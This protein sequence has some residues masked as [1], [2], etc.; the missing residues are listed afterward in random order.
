MKF[1]VLRKSIRDEEY[2]RIVKNN[3]LMTFLSKKVEY[4]ST[5]SFLFDKTVYGFG[6]RRLYILFAAMYGF[7]IF[8]SIYM[9][10]AK[11]FEKLQKILRHSLVNIMLVKYVNNRVR[12]KQELKLHVARR[13]VNNL[14]SRGQR[15]RT[16]A[17]TS[18]KRSGFFVNLIH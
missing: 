5:I 7:G 14:P 6:P 9:V 18:K 3:L 15:S 10:K 17:G 13:K 11:L 1:F 8:V 4:K 16:N 12:L 2:T